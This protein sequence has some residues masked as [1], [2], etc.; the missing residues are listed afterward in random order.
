[1]GADDTVCLLS[2]YPS[3]ETAS[4]FMHHSRSVGSNG[5]VTDIH[6]FHDGWGLCGFKKLKFGNV[7]L[8]LGAVFHGS[9]VRFC[10]LYPYGQCIPDQGRDP[11]I[12]ATLANE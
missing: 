11:S 8:L 10:V 6:S 7:R 9:G 3:C 4:A 12:T 1:M 2:D 5:T